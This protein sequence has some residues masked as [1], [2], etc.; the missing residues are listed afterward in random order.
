MITK[1]E[2]VKIQ[3]RLD[4]FKYN[5]LKYTEFESIKTYNILYNDENII[6]I[7]GYNSEDKLNQYH[8]AC[9]R[10]E[11]L[12]KAMNSENTDVLITFIPKEWV[13]PLKQADFEMYAV[14]NDYF[15]ESINLADTKVDID[16]IQANEYDKVSE[17]TL[18]C[19]GQSR[20]FS[21]QTTEWVR[22]WVEGREP[23]LPSHA[24]NS[25][26]LV[27]RLNT[28]VVGAI[29]IAT[30]AHE[31][32]KGAILWLREVAVHPNYQ[33]KGIARELIKQA[34]QYGKTV[35]ATR[36]FLMADECNEHA[37]HLYESMGF[38]GCPDEVEINMIKL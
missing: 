24:I 16:K 2:Y 34:Y 30:Y 23:A 14:W 4:D 8:W 27:K 3:S 28:N 12:L 29:C 35:G 9:N 13:N 17:V 11:I 36:A 15:S 18:A 19:R 1:D 37:I 32:E 38:K 21:G 26:I 6:L 10:V 7:Y 22:Q 25:T 31:S 5:S 33:R 20:G